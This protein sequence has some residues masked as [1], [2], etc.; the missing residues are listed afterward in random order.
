M[1]I[2]LISESHWDK[3]M[4]GLITLSAYCLAASLM[5]HFT[6]FYAWSLVSSDKDLKIIQQFTGTRTLYIYYIPKVALT[7]M[8]AAFMYKTKGH[9]WWQ[10]WCMGC[11]VVSWVSSAVVQVPLQLRVRER[12][13]RVALAKL[14]ESSWVGT[15]AMVGNAVVLFYVVLGHI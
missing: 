12:Q 2:T 15:L 3:L 1:P 10:W 8:T 9:F 6:L 5:E 7:L 13:D 14:R 11:L 4:L